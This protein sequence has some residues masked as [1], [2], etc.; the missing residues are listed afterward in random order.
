MRNMAEEFEILAASVLSGEATEAQAARLDQL[1]SQDP[2]RRAEFTELRASWTSLKELGSL[3]Q[4]MDVPSEEPPPERLKQWQAELATK[5]GVAEEASSGAKPCVIALP[6]AKD[7]KAHPK[8]TLAL[9]AVVVTL[10]L[11][12]SLYFPGRFSRDLGAASPV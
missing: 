1:L 9:A 5:F 10:A 11:V 3:A 6:V 4:A 2:A 8:I 12:G 7:K